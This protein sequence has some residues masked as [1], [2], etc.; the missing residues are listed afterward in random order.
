MQ[1]KL[2][3]VDLDGTLLSS[4]KSISLRAQKAIKAHKAQGCH[5][6]IC[7]GRPPRMARVFAEL[8]GAELSINFNGAVIFDVVA[9]VV[10][11]RF[12]MEGAQ[13]FEV[14]QHFLSV[15]PEMMALFEAHYGWFCNE[16]FRKHHFDTD[17]L[18]VSSLDNQPD[19]V[20]PLHD[21]VKDSVSSFL[22]RHP[23]LSAK[24]L[25]FELRSFE[26]HCTWSG[27]DYLE[28]SAKGVNKLSALKQVCDDLGVM[29]HE[30]AAF[31]NAHND[32]EMLEWAGVGIAVENASDDA[33][34][35]A[36]VLTQS[37]NDDGVAVTLERWL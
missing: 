15:H 8:V 27:K 14:A 13:A 11:Q 25:S 29:Q 35:V 26:V 6:I 18:A 21:F 4:E 2:I 12:D 17:P 32:V 9:S 5:I 37:N 36:D 23:E 28:L 30:V 16:A 20:G 24:E 22:V 34:A 3:A 1:P 31:G 19:G 33:K 7:T 10:K